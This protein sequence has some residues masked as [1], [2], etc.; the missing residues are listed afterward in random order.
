M[1]TKR[2][3]KELKNDPLDIYFSMNKDK[4][5]IEYITNNPN[6][7]KKDLVF[8]LTHKYLTNE[9]EN[10]QVDKYLKKY[11]TSEYNLIFLQKERGRIIKINRLMSYF[12]L[13]QKLKQLVDSEYINF[14]EEK[15]TY[16]YNK[17]AIKFK[18]NKAEKI[19]GI[20][21]VFFD[22]ILEKG[23]AKT[24]TNKIAEVAEVSIGTIYR[25]FPQGK[26]DIIRKYFEN[27][28]ETTFDL[29]E[30]EKFNKSNM[31]SFFKGFVLNVLR[32]HKENKAYYIAFRSAIL[33]DESLAQAHKERVIE[34]ST[35]IANKMQ[36]KS[37]FFKSREKVRLIRSFVF[38]YNIVNAIIYQHIVFMGL[39]EK[40]EDLIDYISNLLAFTISYLQKK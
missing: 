6:L 24:S 17:R 16:S 13:H 21:K 39:F 4:A 3:N 30:F 18:R 33:S 15:K 36:E 34:T 11:A 28:V 12:T 29:G 14:N 1:E 40:D 10:L 26:K 23:Y 22:L 25:Y 9:N 8:E 5:L 35:R 37:E 38:I 19:E 31:A 32:N 20:Y 2:N 27:S 7:L